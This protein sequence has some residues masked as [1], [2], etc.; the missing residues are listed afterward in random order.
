MTK[1]KVTKKALAS[2]L[3]ALMLC[4][5]MLLGTTYAWFT[6]SVTSTGNIIKSGTLDVEMWYAD[7]TKAVPTAYE[8]VGAWT[9]ASTG[10]IFNYD[11]WEPGYTEVRHIQIKNV[12]TLA[13]KYKVRIVANGTVSDLADVIDVYYMDPAEQIADRTALEAKTPMGTLTAA[14]AGMDATASGNL[15]A[16]EADTVTI[17]MKMQESAGNEYQ[18]K[19]I[20]TDFS[21]QI[22]ATQFT[23]E[24]D[25]F[26]DQYDAGAD[27]NFMPVADAAAFDNALSAGLSASL[28]DDVALGETYQVSP[29][30]AV[31][32]NGN[33][34]TLS[35]QTGTRVINID[36]ANT[37]SVELNGVT[38]DAADKE[39]AVSI[40]GSED[41]EISING[42]DV[43]AN[44]YAINLA[45]NSPNAEIN[46][47][48]STVTGWCAV[49]TWSTNAEINISNST[50]IGNNT[51]TY[52]AEGWNNFST[53]VINEPAA[54]SVITIRNSRIEANQTTGNKQTFV[55][56][57]AG[58]GATVVF[59]NCTFWKDGVE[60]TDMEEIVNN[61]TFTSW[62]AI[63]NSHLTINGVTVFP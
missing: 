4:V 25:S 31:V 12:G 6:D 8:G 39:R 61:I 54:G 11:L 42:S 52:N 13:L 37:A 55:S 36:T 32:I 46:I 20:G 53:I 63:N 5:S 15:R 41:V 56:F 7:G 29:N 30:Q 19:S 17:A 2:S 40:Y 35:S 59:D 33:G 60:I 34:N 26:D 48:N 43:V 57:R 38:V 49:Q 50:L 47:E 16:G 1:T 28:L 58:S 45:S 14:L 3:L 22:V 62:D 18:N 10:A 24:E 23:Y 51:F 21:I 9:D 27:L 44:K